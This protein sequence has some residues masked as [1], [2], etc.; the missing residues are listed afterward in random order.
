MFPRDNYPLE[1]N[2]K[3]S[4]IKFDINYNPNLTDIH[5]FDSKQSQIQYNL[6]QICRFN[7]TQIHRYITNKSTNI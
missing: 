1:K 2:Q 6:D 7:T 3:F 5:K 4:A